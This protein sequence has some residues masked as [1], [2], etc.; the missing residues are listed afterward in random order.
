MGSLESPRTWRGRGA[1][2]AVG[3]GMRW[4]PLKKSERRQ[5]G[6]GGWG[7]GSLGP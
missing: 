3:A 7:M 4:S 2:G 1:V 6:G 5:P